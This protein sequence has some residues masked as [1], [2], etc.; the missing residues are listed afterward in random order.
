M[1]LKNPQCLDLSKQKKFWQNQPPPNVPITSSMHFE[2][3]AAPSETTLQC[4]PVYA[5]NAEV[6]LFP[7]SFSNSASTL[8]SPVHPSFI[9]KLSQLVRASIAD[10]M[11]SAWLRPISA[12]TPAKN[13]GIAGTRECPCIRSLTR[14]V[15]N[16]SLC[17]RRSLQFSGGSSPPHQYAPET[18]SPSPKTPFLCG[19]MWSRLVLRNHWPR[20]R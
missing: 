5:Q 18:G 14:S 7:G 19:T 15:Y 1:V 4:R 11:S 8:F 2:R 13:P 10:D 16:C 17:G 12:T 20:A 3:T 9:E 6:W